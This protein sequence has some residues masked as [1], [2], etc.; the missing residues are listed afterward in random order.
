[1]LLHIVLWLVDMRL[2][3]KIIL[4]NGMPV[5][6]KID[7]KLHKC[8]FLLYYRA[9]VKIGII[10]EVS[11]DLYAVKLPHFDRNASLRR[12][13]LSFEVIFRPRAE[14]M[15]VEDHVLLFVEN[16]SVDTCTSTFVTE[17]IKIAFEG[18]YADT[19]PIMFRLQ[20]VCVA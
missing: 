16:Q 17:G 14:T 12:F 15:F 20:C 6:R 4:Q 11:F 1:M 8:A 19:C 10:F 7:F 13:A 2:F 9:I 18:V 5:N 3:W